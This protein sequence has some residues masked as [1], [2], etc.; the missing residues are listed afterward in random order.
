MRILRNE[1]LMGVRWAELREKGFLSPFFSIQYLLL[2][3]QQPPI[4]PCLPP[5]HQTQPSSVYRALIKTLRTV[6]K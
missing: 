2:K 1:K 5:R 4:F 3:K 6:F